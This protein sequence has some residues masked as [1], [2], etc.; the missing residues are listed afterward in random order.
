[1][2]PLPYIESLVLYYSTTSLLLRYS[3]IKY[4]QITFYYK[5]CSLHIPI[6][7]KYAFP[8]KIFS[9]VEQNLCNYVTGPCIEL[10]KEPLNFSLTC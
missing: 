6:F 1:M 3:V 4:L 9:Q 7:L 10:I 2:L 5:C 8:Y